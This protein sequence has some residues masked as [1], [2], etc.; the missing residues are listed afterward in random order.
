M[1][2]DRYQKILLVLLIDPLAI[3]RSPALRT[4]VR[5]RHIDLLIHMIRHRPV[6][7]PA[8]LNAATASRAAR[9]VPRIALRERRRLTLPRP[10]RLLK[11]GPQPLDVRAQTRVLRPQPANPHTTT[12]IRAVF[13]HTPNPHPTTNARIPARRPPIHTPATFAAARRT[14]SRRVRSPLTHYSRCSCAERAARLPIPQPPLKTS[15]GA[16]PDHAPA[17]PPAST[18]PGIDSHSSRVP[19]PRAPARAVTVNGLL[20]TLRVTNSTTTTTTTTTSNRGCCDHRSNPRKTR[21]EHRPGGSTFFL[22]KSGSEDVAGCRSAV[23]SS[24]YRAAW[25]S[26]S[27]ATLLTVATPGMHDADRKPSRRTGR[28]RRSRSRLHRVPSSQGP[29]RCG[30]RADGGRSRRQQA[31]RQ[32]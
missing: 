19:S 4:T 15:P 10:T 8:M 3:H 12:R 22:A 20:I 14:P 23:S 24:R 21:S 26:S 25:I 5:Q 29:N 30:W 2:A 17:P 18:R 16:P 28:P 31:P 1:R 7:M 13:A 6:R 32:R 27:N 11:L 9:A